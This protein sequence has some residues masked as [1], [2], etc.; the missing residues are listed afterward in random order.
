MNVPPH[1]PLP[2]PLWSPEQRLA[3]SRIQLAQALQEHAGLLLLRKI[4][5]HVN[6][7]CPSPFA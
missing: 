6:A 1:D 7:A 2:P 4:L 5:A 3:M